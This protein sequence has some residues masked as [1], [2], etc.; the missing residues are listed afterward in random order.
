M[1]SSR[2][3]F[4]HKDQTLIFGSP[5]LAGRFFT[6]APPEKPHPPYFSL[7]VYN[8]SSWTDLNLRSLCGYTIVRHHLEADSKVK[9]DIWGHRIF[10]KIYV[11]SNLQCICLGKEW[12][13]TPVFLP[14]EFYGQRIL[15]GYSPW[16]SKTQS[17]LRDFHFH[18]FQMLFASF[19][20]F[21]SITQLTY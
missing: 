7:T 18:F 16:D 2:G 10:S 5:S 20:V 11:R 9:E 17:R 6:A 14:R 12:L 19:A 8:L 21:V 13:P 15:V 4:Q 1:P 3:S